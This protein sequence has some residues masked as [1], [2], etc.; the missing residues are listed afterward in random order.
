MVCTPIYFIFDFWFTGSVFNLK[1]PLNSLLFGIY[2]N[3]LSFLNGKKSMSQD[4][5]SLLNIYIAGTVSGK[6]IFWLFRHFIT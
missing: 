1:G 2:G 4:E 5:S 3:T 6:C